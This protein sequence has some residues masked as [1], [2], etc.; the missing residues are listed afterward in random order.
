MRRN[1]AGRYD[2]GILKNTL[3]VIV[4][5]NVRREMPAALVMDFRHN[6][7]G[8]TAAYEIPC[9]LADNRVSVFP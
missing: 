2:I 1:T 7:C 3:H 6:V 4:G 5:K 8:M 9:K